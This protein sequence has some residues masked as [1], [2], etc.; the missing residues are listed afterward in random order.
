MI[1][2]AAPDGA[3]VHVRA[4]HAKAAHVDAVE[5][6]DRQHR[7]EAA[8]RRPFISS[9]TSCMLSGCASS[10]V[11]LWRQCQS[12]KSPATMSGAS[13]RN[14][15]LDA[16]AQPLDLAAASARR[17]REV[18]AHAMERLRPSRGCRLRNGA[19]RASRSGA[20]RRPGCPSAGWESA[21]GWR[22]RG[23]RGRTRRCARRRSRPRRYRR[24]IRIAAR[25]ASSS[26]RAALRSQVPCTSCR[27][28]MSAPSMRSRSRSSWI[29]SLP[30]EEREPLVDVVGD[31]A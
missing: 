6:K 28:T 11:A 21:T 7:R 13:R 25:P 16:L 1:G 30:V 4:A 5:A 20:R 2:D 15:A 12:L 8:R 22:C 26:W 29:T 14:D 3:V 23:G 27:K 17:E 19:A 31:D 24:E 18:H 9:K 10:C